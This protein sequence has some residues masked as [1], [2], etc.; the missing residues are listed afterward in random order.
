MELEDESE[1]QVAELGQF[2]VFQLGDFYSIDNDGSC[3]G[4]IEGAH[5]LQ[6]GGFARSR[7]SY[8]ADHLA[9]VDVEVNAFE[10]L[11]RAEGFGDVGELYHC[12]C[13]FM[14]PMGLMGLIG[15]IVCV[16]P[17][18][19]SICLASVPDVWCQRWCRGD[20]GR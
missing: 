15:P 1:A 18:R 4:G 19:Q 20:G 3:V 5:D 6:E 10:H 2:L 16:S 7:W 13:F 12:W 11:Q 17:F 14:G 9:F 8:D